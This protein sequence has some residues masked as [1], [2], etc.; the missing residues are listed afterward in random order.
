MATLESLGIVL[1]SDLL[2]VGGGMAGLACA[3]SAKETDPE[4]DVLV[5]DKVVSGWGG[6]A[7]KGGGNISYVTAE[8][9]FETYLRFHVE[10]MGHYLEDQDLLLEYAQQTRPNLEKLE[11]WGVHIFRDDEV[12]AAA[13]VV[14]AA[15]SVVGVPTRAPDVPGS[16]AMRQ[17]GPTAPAVSPNG[18]RKKCRWRLSTSVVPSRARRR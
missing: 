14:L 18:W 10:N 1:T 4:V 16:L 3:I 12:I 5:L 6:K 17:A 15:L 13:L 9:G 8:D 11:S 7:N 2:I